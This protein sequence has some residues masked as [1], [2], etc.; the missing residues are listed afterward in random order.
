M[1]E[2]KEELKKKKYNQLEKK[3]YKDK[4]EMFKKSR[5]CEIFKVEKYKDAYHV[6][7]PLINSKYAYAL[8]INK[9][10]VSQYFFGR[11]DSYMEK[12]DNVQQ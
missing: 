6:V 7:V 5:E 10:Q 2:I 12:M 3:I 4:I 11:V 8:K 1:D 9:E